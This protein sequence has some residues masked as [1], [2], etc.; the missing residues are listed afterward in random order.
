MDLILWRHAQAHDARPGQPDLE[1][2]LT[3]RGQ[4]QADAVGAW[5]NQHLPESA[6]ILVSPAVRTR[7]TAAA[8][9]APWDVVPALAPDQPAE[10]VLAACGW[11]HGLKATTQLAETVV[12][13]GHQ[14]TL[15]QVAARVLGMADGACAVRKGSLWWIRRR[16]RDG[17]AE[18][19]LMTVLNPDWM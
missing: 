16:V 11:P 12:V 6:R 14:P 9:A 3:A 5:L 8:L 17:R 10:A 15:G 18:T 7:D 4:V 13:V 1:R 2:G 19:V